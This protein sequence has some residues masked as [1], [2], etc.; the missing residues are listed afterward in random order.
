MMAEDDVVHSV[1]YHVNERWNLPVEVVGGGRN[2]QNKPKIVMLQPPPSGWLKTHFDGSLANDGIDV[3]VFFLVTT[4][5]HNYW[6]WA[7]C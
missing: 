2:H 6:L 3:G 5:E 7:S 4:R 1:L